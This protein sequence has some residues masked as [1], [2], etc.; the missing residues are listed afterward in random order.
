V[1]G[2]VTSIP[3]CYFV[4]SERSLSSYTLQGFCDASSGAYA[5]VV[6]LRISSESGNTVNFE[7]Q[8]LE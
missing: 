3:R 2:V 1:S 6:Y 4:L 5:A 8:R 7:L